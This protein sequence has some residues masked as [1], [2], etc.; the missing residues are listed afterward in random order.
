MNPAGFAIEIQAD[1]AAFL[2]IAFHHEQAIVAGTELGVAAV[3]GNAGQRAA[4]CG[5]S[6]DAGLGRT[7]RAGEVSAA[8]LFEDHDLAIGGEA[9]TG[10]MTCRGDRGGLAAAG[11]DDPHFAQT[12]VGPADIGQLLA[13]S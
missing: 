9:G 10:I 8:V 12:R 2:G 3:L 7:A 11:A 6:I 1:Q 5:D 4:G 13:V